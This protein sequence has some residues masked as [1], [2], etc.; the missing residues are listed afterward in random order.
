MEPLKQHPTPLPSARELRERRQR[1]LAAPSAPEPEPWPPA[2]TGLPDDATLEA[3]GR[4]VA[5]PCAGRLVPVPTD[6]EPMGG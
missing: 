2:G 1:R 5:L 3:A 4:V 6:T